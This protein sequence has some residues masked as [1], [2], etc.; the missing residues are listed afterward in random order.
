MD[1]SQKCHLLAIIFIFFLISQSAFQPFI[2]KRLNFLETN[3]ILTLLLNILLAN[4]YNISNES[5]LR[6]I[7]TII[8]VFLNI[9]FLV[10]AL[11]MILLYKFH[12]LMNSRLFKCLDCFN[13]FR[14]LAGFF[15]LC[16][17]FSLIF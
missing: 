5:A 13:F 15:Q 2:T 3:L 9:Q 14:E 8:L 1:V 12:K 4:L 11:R 10:S 17:L 6:M 7:L 16:F